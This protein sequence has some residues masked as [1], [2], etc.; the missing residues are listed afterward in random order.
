MG[1]SRI[2]YFQVIPRGRRVRPIVRTL[3]QA[4]KRFKAQHDAGDTS[5]MAASSERAWNAL[6]SLF[7]MLRNE[8]DQGRLDHRYMLEATGWQIDG[9][10]AAE[11]A[12]M[13][14]RGRIDRTHPG[15][16]RVGL[17]TALN[18]A[19]HHDTAVTGYRVDGRGAHYLVLGGA[20]R[21][22]RWVAE[23]LVSTLCRNASIAAAAIRS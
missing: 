3:R 10:S 1:R 4:S 17:R 20:Y 6:A 8:Q 7:E 22:R 15:Y 2:G 5:G 11:Q 9:V 12:A 19:A 18:R 13:V 16:E 14:A 21:R 23:I